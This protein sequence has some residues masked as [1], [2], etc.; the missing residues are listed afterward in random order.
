M[1]KPTVFI[2]HIHTE[3]QAAN[4][5]ESVLRKVLL[6][7]LDVFNSSNRK[8]ITSGDPWRDK[9]IQTL[10]NSTCVLVLA[11]PDS[12]SSPWVNFESGGAWVADTR[13]V[14][15]CIKG[16]EPSSL[17]APLSHL[18]AVNLAHVDDLR[19]LIK[20]LADIAEL[21]NPADFDADEA[22]KT[23]V[24]SW[25]DTRR[26]TGNNGFRAWFRYHFLGF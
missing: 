1:A 9:I 20:L 24:E 15:C 22:V 10:K 4:A 12:V 14:P 17:P 6:G 26:A 13:V 18:Q 2:S 21:D 19:T 23:L 5:L 25:G 3:E 11:S 7:S 16:M 8:S